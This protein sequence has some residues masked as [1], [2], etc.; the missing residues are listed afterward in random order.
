MKRF[1]LGFT[2]F[3][4]NKNYN[5]ALLS[6]DQR[7]IINMYLSQMT[8]VSNE[9]DTLM[10]YNLI[11]LYLTKTFRGRAQAIGKPSRGQRT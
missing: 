4:P 9:I 8:S 11:R 7:K 2:R 3:Y 5:L 6:L 10:R 1:E